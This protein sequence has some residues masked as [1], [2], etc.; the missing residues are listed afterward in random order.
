MEWTAPRRHQGY[1]VPRFGPA[2]GNPRR[3][4][5]RRP[6][7]GGHQGGPPGDATG[8]GRNQPPAAGRRCPPGGAARPGPDDG[9]HRLQPETL[10]HPDAGHG[11][12]RPGRAATA[13]H[14][15]DGP[16]SSRPPER[17]WPAERAQPGALPGPGRAWRPG[18]EG[19]PPGHERSRLGAGLHDDLP[20]AGEAQ[21]PRC[22]C[23]AR[24]ALARAN[25]QSGPGLCVPA[26]GRQRQPRG[27]AHG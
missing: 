9:P 19:S 21:R 5:E 8:P 26:Q 7:R 12:P 3:T 25:A 1:R 15:Q 22:P 10:H 27:R 4:A 20:G 14:A 2:E 18:A 16:R 11:A 17:G 6:G 24:E 13:R 23:T